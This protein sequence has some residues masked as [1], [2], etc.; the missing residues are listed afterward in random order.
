MQEESKEYL[1]ERSE[2]AEATVM[3]DTKYVN[4][5]EKDRRVL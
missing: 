4:R 5:E 1:E 2:K 3:I